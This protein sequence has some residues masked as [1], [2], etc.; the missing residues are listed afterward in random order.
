[1]TQITV[2]FRQGERN[3]DYLFPYICVICV[4]CG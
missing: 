4:I 3:Y 1:M 2:M